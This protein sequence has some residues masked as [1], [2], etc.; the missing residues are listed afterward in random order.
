MTTDPH[1]QETEAAT[2]TD[3]DIDLTSAEQHEQRWYVMLHNDDITPFDYV[4][5]I[6][7]GLFLLSDEMAEHVA[8][9]AHSEGMAVV[10]VRPRAEAERL[11]KV[12]QSRTR[13]DGYPLGFTIEPEH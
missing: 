7:K 11:V 9:T 1:L 3:L 2:L 8:Q 6:L 13:I 5:R 12:A 4:L 10:V